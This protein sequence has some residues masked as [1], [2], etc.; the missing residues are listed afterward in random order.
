MVAF[1]KKVKNFIEEQQLIEEG[2]RLLIACSGGVDSMGL[3]HFFIHFRKHW[4]VDLYVAHVDHMLRGEVSYEDRLFVERFC[5]ENNLPVFSTS[6]P[7]PAILEKEGG[8]SQA[9]C[10]RERYAYFDEIMKQHNI[11]KLVTAHHADDQL[12]T[13]LMSL[14]R[15]GSVNGFKGIAAKRPFSVGMVIRPFLAVAKEEIKEYLEEKGGTFREDASNLKD[16]YTRNR[17]RHH[18]IPLLKKEN[19]QVAI[20]AAELAQNLQQDDEC[21]NELAESRFS[22]VV[23]KAGDRFVL[24]IRQFLK[25][26]LAL[27]RRIILILLNYLYHHL[28]GKNFAIS[29]KIM[30]LCKSQEGNA[31]IYL[32]E[33][34]IAARSYDIISF[35]KLRTSKKEEPQTIEIG[36]WHDFNGF[37]LYI[38]KL[39][40]DVSVQNEAIAYFFNASTIAFPLRVRTRKERDRIQ[41]KGM[42]DPK[43]LS[44]LFIDEKI[45]LIERDGWPILVDS[46][47]EILAVLGVRV[48]HRFSKTRRMDDDMV[49]FIEKISDNK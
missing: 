24:H 17:F 4:K 12:E 21:L 32:P 14:A 30:D 9:I 5:K 13:M 39:P 3:V 6:I 35:F 47:D 44:R 19:S 37:R 16:D 26:P 42:Q 23:E 1:E 43:R 46:N 20:H 8:N 22:S 34:Y 10:R 31:M 25:E 11:N 28:D 41:L 38:E 45:P 18:I 27:Q 36:K 48:N 15:A 29:S 7:I 40:H 49:M 2:D 33:Q